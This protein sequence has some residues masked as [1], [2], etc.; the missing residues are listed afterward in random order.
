MDTKVQEQIALILKKSL[1]GV[2]FIVEQSPA[3]IQEYLKW[4]FTASLI[5]VGV[6]LT[7]LIL[8]LIFTTIVCWKRECF[9]DEAFVIFMIF[10]MLIMIVFITI[11]TRNAKDIL[12]IKT[13]PKVFLMDSLLKGI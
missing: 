3:F 12:K 6:S 9:D 10:S 2:D 1:A 13:A 4:N 8:T 5:W 7:I 11:G